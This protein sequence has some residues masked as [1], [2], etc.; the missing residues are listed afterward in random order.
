MGEV[1]APRLICD[2]MLQRLGRW[3]RAAGYDTLIARPGMTDREL[4]H[5]ARAQQRRLITRDRKLLEFRHA[6]QYAVLLRGNDL[7]SN[8]REITR[9][10]AIDW[11]HAP[12][13]R[14]MVCNTPIES[15]PALPSLPLPNDILQTS[16]TVFYCPNCEQYFWEGSHVRRMRQR[17][18]G[19]AK[20]S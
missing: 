2:E 5:L 11:L 13:S 4:L 15:R 20:N 19:L 3:L 18:E 12:F 8:L 7:E 6:R 17:L 9:H 10:L 14:C 16:V 1:Q